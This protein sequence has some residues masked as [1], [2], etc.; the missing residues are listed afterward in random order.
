MPKPPAYEPAKVRHQLYVDSLSLHCRLE[1]EFLP[2][3]GNKYAH[4]ITRIYKSPLQFSTVF[5]FMFFYKNNFSAAGA[6]R[7]FDIAADA[8]IV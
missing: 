1:T 2:L 6:G 7:L 8:A 3:T 5:N 4:F